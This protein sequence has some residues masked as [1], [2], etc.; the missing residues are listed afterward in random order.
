[1]TSCTAIDLPPGVAIPTGLERVDI[2][3]I[4]Q[5]VEIVHLATDPLTPALGWGR[6]LFFGCESTAL[7]SAA[8]L[9]YRPLLLAYSRT[10]SGRIVRG[11][12]LTWRDQRPDSIYRTEPKSPTEAAWLATIAPGK[13]SEPA[14]LYLQP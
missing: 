13:P 4:A 9:A 8:P 12:R 3:R 10:A 2:E 6:E 1:M 5:E 14:W 11:W 7:D